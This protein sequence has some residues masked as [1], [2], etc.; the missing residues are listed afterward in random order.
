VREILQVS[1]NVGIIKLGQRLGD[2]R[3]ADYITRMGF[4]VKTGVDLPGEQ[5]GLFRPAEEWSRVSVGAISMGQEIAAT[6]LQVVSMVAAVA[7]GGTW[8]RPHVVRKIEDPRTGQV[9]TIEPEGSRVISAST[10]DDLH[11][12]LE[13]VITDGTARNA[14]MDFYTAAAKTGTAQKYDPATGTYSLTKHVA[15]IAGYAPATRPELAVI[16]AI[17]EPS[18]A[19]YYGGQV[20]SP[21]FKRI[22]EEVLRYRSVPPDVPAPVDADVLESN[23]TVPAPET[24]MPAGPVRSNDAPSSVPSRPAP[25]DVESDWEVVDVALEPETPET[26][27]P[28]I[29]LPLPDFRGRSLREVTGDCLRLGLRCQ[30]NG[31]GTAIAQSVVPGTPVP[32][33]G[34]V[35]IRF[36]TRTGGSVNN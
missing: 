1:S 15:S 21:V 14:R 26:V 20:A 32:R 5:R 25:A 13:A 23:G 29:G 33:G 36:S 8:Y 10:A 17:D 4:G 7:N 35:Q 28:A 11:D 6:P 3:L 9:T 24:G 27:D 12:A 18:G 2:E 34:R 30:S 19:M 22:V 31:S 16:V